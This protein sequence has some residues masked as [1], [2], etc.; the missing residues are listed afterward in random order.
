MKI[1]LG[2]SL[3]LV[4]ISAFTWWYVLVYWSAVWSCGTA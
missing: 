3:Y 2:G 1:F 4:N